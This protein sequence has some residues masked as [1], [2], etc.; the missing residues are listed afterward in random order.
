MTPDHLLL[1]ANGHNSWRWPSPVNVAHLLLQLLK[2]GLLRCAQFLRGFVLISFFCA[3]CSDLNWHK[4]STHTLTKL[5]RNRKIIVQGV[6]CVFLFQKQA[7]L[8]H[9]TS[10]VVSN[11]SPNPLGWVG[12][13][14]SQWYTTR[15]IRVSLQRTSPK[16]SPMF[17]FKVDQ[18]PPPAQQLASNDADIDVGHW[19]MLLS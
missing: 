7:C 13:L 18:I 4:S 2:P 9:S 3:L 16:G 6:C 15:G 19:V 10:A 1:P 14:H 8:L 17:Y 11:L 12:A 5:E